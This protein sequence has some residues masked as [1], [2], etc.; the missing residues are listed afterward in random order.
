MP[1]VPNRARRFWTGID[2]RT[3]VNMQ[4]NARF[5]EG[6]FPL[7]P[8]TLVFSCSGWSWNHIRP[9][10]PVTKQRSV[11]ATVQRTIVRPGLGPLPEPML[12]AHMHALGDVLHG[13]QFEKETHVHQSEDQQAEWERIFIHFHSRDL[14]T[15]AAHRVFSYIKLIQATK[16]VGFHLCRLFISTAPNTETCQ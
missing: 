1:S 5:V 11:A 10:Q 15:C 7:H 2:A 4:Q 13:P 9:Q 16:V 6:A 12:W 8:P 14:N 3:D